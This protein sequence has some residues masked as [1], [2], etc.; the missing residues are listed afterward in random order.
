MYP[1][2][3]I[4]FAGLQKNLG[5]AGLALVIIREDPL[6]HA[7]P[8]TPMLLNHKV[9]E[10]KHSLANTNNTFA[11]YIITSLVLDWLKEQGGAK[12]E[13][14][15]N[16]KASHVYDFIDKSDFF[17]GTA[18]PDHRSIMNVI[19]LADNDLLRFFKNALY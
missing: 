1:N 4:I 7:F 14:D 2:S 16:L 17:S 13:E 12:I 9:Y 18:H 8:E 11:I 10:S 5:P 15:N 3:G 6:N 19:N